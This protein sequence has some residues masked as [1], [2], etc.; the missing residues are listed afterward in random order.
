ML[1]SLRRTVGDA[2]VIE[3]KPVTGSE[4]FSY[5]ANRVPGFFFFLGVTP[6]DQDWRTAPKNHSPLFFADERALVVGVR[7]LSHEAVDYLERPGR[8][9]RARFRSAR[10]I[11]T[12]ASV[13]AGGS[14]TM[15]AFLSRP[16]SRFSL[17]R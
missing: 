1:P 7:A 2:N 10:A 16:A 14:S 11:R 9:R 6:P 8:T 15:M 17:T 5:Y 3:G 12:T 13:L 4:D